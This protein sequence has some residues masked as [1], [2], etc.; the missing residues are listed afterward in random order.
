MR[1]CFISNFQF[2]QNL[3]LLHFNDRSEIFESDGYHLKEHKNTD[4]LYKNKFS[5]DHRSF[6]IKKNDFLKLITHKRK[7]KFFAENHN[8]IEITIIC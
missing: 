2:S 4:I 6:V 5:S 7:E 3:F 1:F 8:R